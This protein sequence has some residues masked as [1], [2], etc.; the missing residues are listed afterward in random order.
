MMTA[1]SAT[2]VNR[3]MTLNDRGHPEVGPNEASELG[4][5]TESRESKSRFEHP[6]WVWG[7]PFSPITLAET[8]VAIGDLIERKQPSIVIT[9]NTHYIML[10]K[11]NAD[12]RAINERAALILADG[13][14]PV[15]SSKLTGTPLPER[16]AGSDLIFHLTEAAAEKGHRLF[17]LG[18]AEGVADEA[19]RRLVARYPGLQIVGTECPPFRQP[20]PEEEA[21]LIDRIRSARPDMLFVAFGQPKGERWIVR[22]IDQLGVPVCM[23]VGASLDFAAGRIRRA[24][25]WMQKTGME[26]AFRLSLEPKR[27]FTRYASNALFIARMV[28]RDLGR[29]ISR[30]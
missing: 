2:T 24:P 12:V 30:G 1:K 28:A 17:F 27:L 18:G 29:K 21:A 8:V 7:V 3:I 22:H 25:R 26:W 10:S 16:V 20:T 13:A 5:P 15:W 11:Q 23:Q 14:P 6:V 9:A 4:R 19:A